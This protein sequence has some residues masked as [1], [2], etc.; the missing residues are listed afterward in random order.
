M[1]IHIYNRFNKES[2]IF[3]LQM[4]KY[5]MFSRLGLVWCWAKVFILLLWYENRG[6]DQWVSESLILLQYSFTYENR[7]WVGAQDQSLQMIL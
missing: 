3:F 1:Y 5:Y 4:P 2:R 7:K 6:E